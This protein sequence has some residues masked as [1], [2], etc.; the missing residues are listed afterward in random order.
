MYIDKNPMNQNAML[1]FTFGWYTHLKLHMISFQQ[2]RPN[3]LMIR[4]VCKEIMQI[5]FH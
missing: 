5:K 3:I 1:N 4:L 2:N